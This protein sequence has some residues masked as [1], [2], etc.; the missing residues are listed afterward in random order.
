MSPPQCPEKGNWKKATWLLLEGCPK[1]TRYRRRGK[2]VYLI[3][4]QSGHCIGQLECW[5]DAGSSLE[6]KLGDWE[7]PGNH[8]KSLDVDLQAKREGIR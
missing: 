2:Q 3:V 8:P 5:L 7:V 4:N 1:E 6:M